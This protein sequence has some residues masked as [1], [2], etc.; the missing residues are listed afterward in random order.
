MAEWISKS[1]LGGVTV[2]FI[3]RLV[4]G[5][6]GTGADCLDLNFPSL[7]SALSSSSGIGRHMCT[8]NSTDNVWLV[9][10]VPDLAYFDFFNVQDVYNMLN[11]TFRSGHMLFD[12]PLT[13]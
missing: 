7:F 10:V 4:G 6:G 3:R 12:A 13:L 1:G 5:N 2:E 8:K 11:S 9:S